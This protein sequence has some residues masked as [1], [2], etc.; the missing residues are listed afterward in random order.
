VETSTVRHLPLFGVLSVLAHAALFAALARSGAAIPSLVTDRPSQPLAGETLE[1]EPS[2]AVTDE[3]ETATA[4]ATATPTSTP[5]PTPTPTATPT[6]TPIPRVSLP[7]P[8]AM[9]ANLPRLFGAVGARFA[10]DLVVTFTRAF[11]QA[12][13]ADAVWSS[14][15]FGSAGH[16]QIT[17][18][19]N[20]E[21]RIVRSEI[22][23]SPSPALR[24]GIARTLTLLG[25]R[26]FTASSAVTKLSITAYVSRDDAHDGLHGDVFALSAG[27]ISGDVGTAF[28]ALPPSS[29]P[30]R[31]VDVALRLL[32]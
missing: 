20:E 29:G 24:M 22:G 7:S 5:T 23:G 28:F 31:R 9:P 17:M 8:S 13:S 11:P 10:T 3:T 2:P 15:P 18:E 12:A 25:S 14:V 27:S 26:E 19:L 21:G 6:P 30:G 1:I 16:A 32:H 4:T